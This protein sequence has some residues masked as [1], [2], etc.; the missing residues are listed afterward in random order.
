MIADHY[1][2]LARDLCEEFKK[3]PSRTL[4][5]MM[6]ER[7]KPIGEIDF[8]KAYDRIRYQR[9]TNNRSR[10]GNKNKI[11]HQKGTEKMAMPKPK[12]EMESWAVQK[13]KARK[14]LVLSDIHVPYHDEKALTV[15][16]QAGIDAGVDAVLL[17]GDFMD[18]F[19][20]SRYATD[21]LQRD[22]KGE[23]EMGRAMLAYLR[24]EFAGCQIWWKLGNHEERWDHWLWNKAPEVYGLESFKVEALMDVKRYNVRV[25]RD[26]MPIGVN[27]LMILH[28]HE[29]KF[30]I[31]NPVNPARGLY[32]RA[33]VP[34]M[35]GH[36]H[37]TSEHSEADLNGKV[38]TTWSLGCLCQLRPRYAPLNKWNHGFAIVD[39][40]GDEDFT[41]QNF[42]IHKGK[43]L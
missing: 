12:T 31:S 7:S 32:M 35:M 14:V 1:T 39:T 8:N 13:L 28:G 6:V 3:T 37:Q 9:G 2:K 11:E 16:I 30:A 21:P 23:L 25:I 4:A 29:Y 43:I 20:V 24:E 33:K 36:L 17:N 40:T 18:F 5:R 42:R 22:F 15:A 41:V 38:V 27:K 19:S 10:T 34:S 26:C